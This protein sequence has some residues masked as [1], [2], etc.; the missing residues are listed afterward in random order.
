[1]LTLAWAWKKQ[2]RNNNNTS[3]LYSLF[4]LKYI[5][6]DHDLCKEIVQTLD[7]DESGEDSLT[8][9]ENYNDR[10]VDCMSLWRRES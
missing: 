1:M 6:I 5:Y 8:I 4:F 3:K 9:S 7:K 10:P 2:K